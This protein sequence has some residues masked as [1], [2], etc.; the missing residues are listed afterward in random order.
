VAAL[1]MFIF[2]LISLS[3]LP[4]ALRADMLFGSCFR[5]FLLEFLGF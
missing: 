5:F 1:T 4:F 3:H 2:G